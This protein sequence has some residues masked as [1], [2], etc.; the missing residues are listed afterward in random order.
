M[1]DK[2]VNNSR[3]DDPADNPEGLPLVDAVGEGLGGELPEAADNAAALAVT[4]CL[5]RGEV[6]EG[7][8]ALGRCLVPV[9]DVGSPD[10]SITG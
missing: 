6:G 4:V 2:L 10:K 7:A 1:Y 5:P 3:P 9:P 8:P